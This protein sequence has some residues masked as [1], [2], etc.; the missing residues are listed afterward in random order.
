MINL[1]EKQIENVIYFIDKEINE[2]KKLL[3]ERDYYYHNT[4][5]SWNEFVKMVNARIE[6][7]EDIKSCFNVECSKEKI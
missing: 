5:E 1:D 7:L 3:H 2:T 4:E 6:Y